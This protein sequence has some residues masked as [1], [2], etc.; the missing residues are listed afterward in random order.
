MTKPKSP[1][2][3]Y[4]ARDRQD[5][6]RI[7]RDARHILMEGGNP[8]PTLEA[9][10]RA[11]VR[12]NSRTWEL[13]DQARQAVGGQRDAFQLEAAAA[14]IEKDRA[15]SKAASPKLTRVPR[16][17]LRVTLRVTGGRC[18]RPIA[19]GSGCSLEPA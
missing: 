6:A 15:P 7:L 2:R 9:A 5:A 1:L 13:V 17:R 18:G 11:G 19:H 8:F 14:L 16:C 10:R 12:P 4:S 3:V